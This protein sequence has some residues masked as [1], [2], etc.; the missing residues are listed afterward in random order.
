MPVRIAHVEIIGML[1]AVAARAVLDAVAEAQIAGDVAGADDVLHRLDHVAAVVEARPER[2]SSTM[3]QGLSLRCRNV[4]TTC[5][6]PST[7]R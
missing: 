6:L 3:S 2:V 5:S 7:Q 4:P 1:V